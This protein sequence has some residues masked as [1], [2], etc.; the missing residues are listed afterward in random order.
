MIPS[1]CSSVI[2]EKRDKTCNPYDCTLR[3]TVQRETGNIFAIC[4]QVK[5]TSRKSSNNSNGIL[6]LGLPAPSDGVI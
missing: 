5:P 2:L 4:S 1:I 6:T 3:I